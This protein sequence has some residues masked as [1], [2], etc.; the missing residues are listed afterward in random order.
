MLMLS[1]QAELPLDTAG[2][3]LKE[4]TGIPSTYAQ[5]CHY[6]PSKRANNEASQLL[7]SSNIFLQSLARITLSYCM[8]SIFP[9]YASK[10]R[11]SALIPKLDD[12]TMGDL[13]IGLL[14]K[15]LA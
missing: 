15:G 4:G 13:L 9:P 12:S 11:S 6:T 3:R 8:F 1:L 14:R 7:H 2:A 5:I 10:P